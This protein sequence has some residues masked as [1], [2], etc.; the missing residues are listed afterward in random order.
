MTGFQY[1]GSIRVNWQPRQT[2]P[3]SPGII[4][5]I[6]KRVGTAKEP[7]KG[8]AM[9]ELRSW[10]I[11]SVEL[12]ENTHTMVCRL[13]AKQMRMNYMHTAWSKLGFIA[14]VR[15]TSSFNTRTKKASSGLAPRQEP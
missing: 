2:I 9:K 15:M 11:G 14:A 13:P 12:C 4:W 7:R 1:T 3:P 6:L 5:H 8:K 10:R